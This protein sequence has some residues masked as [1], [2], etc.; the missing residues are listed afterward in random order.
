MA[1][2][3]LGKKLYQTTPDGGIRFISDRPWN[4]DVPNYVY[5]LWMPV[6][7]ICA[8]GVYSVYCRLGR[9]GVVKAITQQRIARACRIGTSRLQRINAALEKCG[10]VSIRVPQGQERT[11]HYTTEITIHEAPR[12]VKPEFIRE[13]S[14]LENYEPLS[15]W[16][17][18]EMP[19]GADESE[20]VNPKWDYEAIPNG[21]A[22]VVPL[23]VE[24]LN[25]TQETAT[26]SWTPPTTFQGWRDLLNHYRD[27][28]NRQYAVLAKM[29][30]TL[31]PNHEPV[32]IGRVGNLAKKISV[33]RLAQLLWETSTRPPSGRVLDYIQAT[34][35]KRTDDSD[36]AGRITVG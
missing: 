26:P 2:K 13:W 14:S 18:A 16:L 23:D 32:N 35:G 7:G 12:T 20:S 27:R 11:K 6:L 5:D 31:Y 21:N 34:G 4:V 24:P 1:T 19:I 29:H 36:S 17:V 10:F 3:R 15:T 28:K 8:V 9:E 25:T 33:G 30:D 22:E